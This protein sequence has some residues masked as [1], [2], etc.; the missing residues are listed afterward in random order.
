MG[1]GAIGW[2]ASGAGVS[3]LTAFMHNEDASILGDVETNNS[4]LRSAYD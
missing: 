2:D 4:C 1:Q 3:D